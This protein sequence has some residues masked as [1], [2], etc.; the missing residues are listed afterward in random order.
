MATPVLLAFNRGRISKLALART[1]FK[2]TALSS[3]IQTNWMPRALGS[4]MLRPGLEYTGATRSNAQSITIP[5]IFSVDD[6]ARIEL[7]DGKMRVW[8]E[9]A[10]VTRPTVTAAITN[11]TFNTDLTAWSD[12]DSGS[13]VSSWATGGF[14]SLIGTGT[15]AAKRRQQVT[16]HQSGTR[17]ALNIVIER[18]PVTIRVGSLAGKDDYITETSL[19]TG[20]HSLAFTPSG[21]FFIDLFSYTEYAALVDSVA[22]APAGTMEVDAPWAEADL[23]SIRWDQSGDVVF[24][25]C[26]GYR[27]RRIERRASDSW[28]VVVYQSNN[29]PFR[30]QNVGPITITPSAA[31]GDIT[32]TS[33]AD[34]FRAT[35]VGALF[36]LT[37]AGQSADAELTGDDQYTDPIRVSGVD[38][39]RSF[40]IVIDGTWSGT[41]TLQ[42]SV[43]APGDWVDASTAPYTSNTAVSYDD[44]LDNQIIYYR[45][46]FKPGGFVSGTAEVRLTYSSG[47]QTGIARVTGYTSATSVSAQVLTAFAGTSATSD[48]SES[49]WSEYRGF[50]SAVAFYEG[51]LWWSG[52]DR[53]WGSVS[54]AFDDYDDTTEGDS[55]PISRSIGSG[56]VDL[57][58][59]MIPVQR[60]LLGAGG[61]IWSARSSSLDEP[62]TPTNF[63]LKD[64]S[65]QGSAELAAVKIDT[66]AIFVQRSQTRLY[67]ASY[68]S[69]SYDYGVN[70]L[71]AHVP[72][73]GEP[74]IVRLAVQ[75]QPE[76]RVH[77]IRSDGT[78]AIQVYDKAEDVNCWVDFETD[79]FV[80]DCVVLPGIVEDQVYYT[81]RRTING[82]TVRYHEK[83]ALESECIGGVLNKQADSF[84][85][86]SGSGAL[87]AGLSHL[88]GEEVV[89]WADGEDKGTFIV[90]GAAVAQS[91]TTGAIVGLPYDAQYKSTKL[92]YATDGTT[93][94]ALCQKKKVSKIGIIACNIHPNG[95]QYGPDFTTMDDLPL[96]E[97]AEVIPP[98]TVRV[99]YDEEMFTFAGEWTTDARLCLQASAP[100][101]VTILACVID[102]ETHGS[103]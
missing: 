80:E 102:M 93:D 71:T 6:T 55:G 89:V 77:A 96:V 19:S 43:S 60:L 4:M 90:T 23:T 69:D 3:E 61:S 87:V 67:E 11:G 75:R 64:I 101:P 2:R 59:W 78:V 42:Y 65:S 32:L 15:A 34:L 37:Q 62:L 74:G 44:T 22:V 51:R 26:D 86:V 20:A 13:A 5:F 76:T 47:S 91:Y 50:P 100:R 94:T 49:Y 52:K 9:D 45:L 70:E 31:A 72:E 68:Q 29:G 24:V 46:G 14:L 12:Q 8:V 10:L 99:A 39:S 18:G 73:I 88:E 79:G 92:A 103:P 17:H 30:I 84:L 35:Q 54:D 66:S 28:S 21:D 53:Q 57:I 7:T 63:N 33:S 56:P 95:L 38:A 25:A 27:Q 85:V 97:D 48:W 1:D 40:A 41:L 36:R 81:I 16:V 58:N 83:W 98:S 82:N